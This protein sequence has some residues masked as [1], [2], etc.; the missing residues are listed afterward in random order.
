MGASLAGDDQSRRRGSE[1][2]TYQRQRLER[3]TGEVGAS[4]WEDEDD[5][6]AGETNKVAARHI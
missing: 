3:G 6:G 4:N 2:K 1:K 5:T